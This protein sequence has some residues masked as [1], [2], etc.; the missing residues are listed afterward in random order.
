M[1]SECF[2]KGVNALS[3]AKSPPAIQACELAEE[4][5]DVNEK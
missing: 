3:G 4:Q 5:I 1:I 2:G